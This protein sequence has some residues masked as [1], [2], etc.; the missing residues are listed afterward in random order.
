VAL[1]K[2]SNNNRFLVIGAASA[3]ALF[4]VFLLVLANRPRQ[5]DEEHLSLVESLP[6]GLTVDGLPYIGDPDAPVTMTVY[7]D[8]GCPNCRRF[9]LEVEPG[10]LSEYVAEGKVRLVIYQLAFVNQQSL[11]GAEGAACAQDQ[12]RYWEYRD[13]LFNNQG[14]RQFTRENLVAI[15]EELG[16]DRQAFTNCYDFANYTQE[17]I[18]RSQRASN[19]GINATPTSDIN[20]QRHVGVIPFEQED[21]PGIKQLLEAAL[22]QAVE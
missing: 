13:A 12:G 22:A 11:P 8:L 10:I 4:V 7:E 9:Y 19:F 20:G 21:P 3:V 18:D 5:A 15:A 6:K 1:R 2:S 16:L 17:I 14:V